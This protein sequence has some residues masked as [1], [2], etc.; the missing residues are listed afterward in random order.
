MLVLVNIDVSTGV[1]ALAACMWGLLTGA[2]LKGVPLKD[3]AGSVCSAGADSGVRLP[4]LSC[5]RIITFRLLVLVC[6]TAFLW[7]HVS[8]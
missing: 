6:C 8:E 2:G 3:L 5:G 7:Q 1:T 4:S